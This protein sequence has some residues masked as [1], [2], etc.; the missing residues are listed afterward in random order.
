M[1]IQESVRR[2]GPWYHSVSLSDGSVTPGKIDAEKKFDIFSSALPGNLSK[3]SVLDLGCSSGGLSLEFAKRGAQVTG[4]D[5]KK[6]EIDQAK[7]VF[8]NCGFEGN[9]YRD[10]VM[11]AWKYGHFDIVN[12]CGL[13]YHLPYPMLF[14]DQLSVICR[15]QLI[16]ATRISPRLDDSM[17][18]MRS[19]S[20]GNWWFPT[21]RCVL[22]MLAISGF[23]GSRVLAFNKDRSNM[24]CSADAPNSAPV[25]TEDRDLFQMLVDARSPSGERIVG[26]SDKNDLPVSQAPSVPV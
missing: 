25:L 1:T 9:F 4:I 19:E 13:L 23:V 3:F 18:L 24:F 10:D 11:N 26:P 14:L 15:K 22:K 2:L 20:R 6:R 5:S 17:E 16:L 7:F 12:A 8:D 21:E